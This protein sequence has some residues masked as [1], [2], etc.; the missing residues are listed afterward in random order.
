MAKNM[1][2]TFDFTEY[3]ISK[4]R[5][6]NGPISFQ[7]PLLNQLGV[8]FAR[9]TQLEVEDWK[10][11]KSSLSSLV[12]SR[13][14]LSPESRWKEIDLSNRP[15]QNLDIGN[16]VNS[17]KHSQIVT[18][19]DNSRNQPQQSSFITVKKTSKH[20]TKNKI[21]S[22][23][24]RNARES[25]GTNNIQRELLK[26]AHQK[27]LYKN[28]RINQETM[29]PIKFYSCRPCAKDFQTRSNAY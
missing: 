28:Y 5:Q 21:I 1:D 15:P 13:Q 23:S 29:R 2:I 16:S 4:H 12:L 26:A 18:N 22:K 11:N 10:T 6:V 27:Y 7:R 9:F 25:Q 17:N 19:T 24:K 14:G 8:P 3:I 20:T